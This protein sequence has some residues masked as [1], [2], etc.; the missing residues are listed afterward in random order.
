MDYRLAVFDLDGTI[1]DT[2]G[3][4]HMSVNYALAAE[5]L[6][7]RTLEEVREDVGNGIR[8]LI[9]RSVP[10][11]TD[12]ALEE[13]VF[14][15]FRSHYSRHCMDLTR[16][17]DDIKSVLLMLKHIGVKLAVV[18]NKADAPV[19]KLCTH[20]FDGIFDITVGE[21]EGIRRKPAPDSVFSVCRQLSMDPVEGVYIGDSDV[22]IRTAQNAGMDSISVSWGFRD[23]KFLLENEAQSI[24]R[25]PKDLLRMIVGRLS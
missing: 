25:E 24:A 4:L 6:P 13:K 14:R 16:P 22:D 11:G 18:S 8:N 9:S 21:R 23:E 7:R 17:Y 5:N 20:F 2:L 12:P 1:L 15:E 10:G 19:Q 3:D